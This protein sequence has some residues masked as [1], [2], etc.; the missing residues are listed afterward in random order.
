MFLK[1]IPNYAQMST[2]KTIFN[3]ISNHTQGEVE[4][5]VHL[6]EQ[7]GNDYIISQDKLLNDFPE[8]KKR[9]F[10]LSEFRYLQLSLAVGVLKENPTAWYKENEH[11][12][13]GDFIALI[14]DAALRVS[15]DL[16]LERFQASGIRCIRTGKFVFL[17]DRLTE[18]Q[19][20]DRA[21]DT[22]SF[23]KLLRRMFKNEH[24]L[25]TE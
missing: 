10:A 6:V 15:P 14:L 7:L 18:S 22:D 13:L 11:E 19:L 12:Q 17:S 8:L 3:L 24:T 1:L 21:I 2:E 25:T 23:E 20:G 4:K 9:D 5:L 16:V